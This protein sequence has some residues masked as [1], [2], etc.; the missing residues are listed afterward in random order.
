M[1]M[2]FCGLLIVALLTGTAAASASTWAPEA[3][4]RL[5][6]LP[7]A[8]MQKAIER[9][10]AG[11]DL[12]AEMNTISGSLGAKGQSVSDLDKASRQSKGDTR[13][14]LK[15]Q[16]LVEK[17]GYVELLGRRQELK[18]QQLTTKI[19]LY[20]DLM[21]TMNR[22]DANS[23][24][25]AQ[26]SAQQKQARERFERTVEAV[27][28]KLL[29]TTM[30]EESRYSRDYSKNR[31]AIEKLVAAIDTHP[32][33]RAAEDET[34]ELVSKRD[35]LRNMITD[36]HAELAVLQQEEQV[37]GY[38]AKLVALDA[39]AL[40]EQV[41]LAQGPLGLASGAEPDLAGSVDIFLARP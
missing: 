10:F 9:D 13:I 30:E 18:R 22:V 14:E 1:M 11:S 26:V 7:A 3:S 15:H 37:L 17:R 24:I 32:M 39:M 40:A 25:A 33:S 4:E 2:R 41:D 31:Q 5:V 36:A 8:Q 6:K 29:E 28:L 16:A 34:G 21:T 19:K 35:F 27:D 38:M 23:A 12:A 20:E